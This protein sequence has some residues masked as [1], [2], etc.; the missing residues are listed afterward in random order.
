MLIH[1]LGPQ[2]HC[3]SDTVL[4]YIHPLQAPRDLTARGFPFNEPDTSFLNR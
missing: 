4:C 2:V 3:G 1:K